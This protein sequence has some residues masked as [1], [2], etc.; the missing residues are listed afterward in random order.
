M[1]MM[2]VLRL[3]STAHAGHAMLALMRKD[4]STRERSRVGSAAAL[5]NAGR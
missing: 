1:G 2:G 5:L 3:A 4:F